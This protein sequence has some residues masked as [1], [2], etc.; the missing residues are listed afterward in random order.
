VHEAKAIIGK[1]A[2]GVDVNALKREER[3]FEESGPTLRDAYV[4]HRSGDAAPCSV[5]GEDRGCAL[6]A[7]E[8][9]P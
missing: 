6:E 1:M 3:H 4:A 8:G 5:P 9:A 2:V 7:H